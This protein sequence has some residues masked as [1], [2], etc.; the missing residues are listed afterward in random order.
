MASVGKVGIRAFGGDIIV[1]AGARMGT[2]LILVI[3]ALGAVDGNLAVIDLIAADVG[4]DSSCLEVVRFICFENDMTAAA[5]LVMGAVAVIYIFTPRGSPV[6]KSF[7]AV[8]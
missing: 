7:R 2:E 1:P 3:A 4:Q 5:A 8:V 6:S